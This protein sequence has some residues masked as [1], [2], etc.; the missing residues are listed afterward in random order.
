VAKIV[1][2]FDQGYFDSL[3]G[4]DLR[5]GDH[6]YIKWGSGAVQQVEIFIEELTLGSLLDGNVVELP[7]RKAYMKLSV[8]GHTVKVYLNGFEAKKAK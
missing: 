3:E 2:R 4:E 1:T 8:L 5:T 6:V 7:C